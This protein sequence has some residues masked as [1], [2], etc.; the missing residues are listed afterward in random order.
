[1]AK[2]PKSGYRP[3]RPGGPAASP[4]RVPVMPHNLLARPPPPLLSGALALSALLLS[5]PVQAPAPAMGQPAP[6]PDQ[7][8][9]SIVRPAPPW[10]WLANGGEQA[11]LGLRLL[12]EADTHGI[13]PGRYGVDVLARRLAAVSNHGTRAD[14]AQ[15]ERDLDAALVRYLTELRLGRV[16]SIY[17]APD[18]PARHFDA[19][20][21]LAKALRAGRLEQA[22]EEAAPDLPLYRRV[23]AS[24]AHY[25]ALARSHPAWPALPATDGVLAPGSPYAG[26]DLLRERLRLLGDLGDDTAP[27]DGVQR[28][29]PALAAGL[30]RFQA[31]HGLAPSGLPDAPT[32]AALAV[33]LARRAD[34]L[35]LTLERLRWLPP[36]APGPMVAVNL[37]AYRLWAFDSRDGEA[38]PPLEMRVIV[39]NAEKTPTPPL[40]GQ[41]RYLELNPYWNVPRS[42][43][44]N[45]IIPK[46]TRNPSWLRRN[47]M[48]LVSAGG[49]VLGADHAPG[50]LAELRAGSARLRQRPGPKNALGALKFGMPNAEDIYLHATPHR[51]LF[52]RERR[53]LSHGCIRVERPLA[54]AQFVL[55]GKDGWDAAALDAAIRDGKTRTLALPAPVPVVLFYATALVDHAGR[56]LFADDIYGM[57]PPLMRALRAG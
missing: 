50:A 7:A 5:A 56:V 15:F 6:P 11:R 40:V 24:L 28:L 17:L 13:D 47:G 36:P 42:I 29:T 3:V 53:D 54:L 9:P 51:K 21:C 18:D 1:M 8:A 27:A 41:I 46:L 12:R 10:P 39:G 37:P 30:S 16:P 33:P 34:Q 19:A 48:E 38:A 43:V 44:K 35:A 2:R 52:D 4:Q 45:E 49:Q 55:A 26:A 14:F 57:D 23:R 22:V 20:A 32:L 25:R 31:R